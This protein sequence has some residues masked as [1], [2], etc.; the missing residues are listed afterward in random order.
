M[1][2]EPDGADGGT[3]AREKIATAKI[4]DHK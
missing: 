3:A 2:G 1:R 4:F